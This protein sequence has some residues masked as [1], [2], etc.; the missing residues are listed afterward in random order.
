MTASSI[1]H[2]KKTENPFYGMVNTLSM[3]QNV[4]KVADNPSKSVIFSHLDQAWKECKESIDKRQLFFSIM[5]SFGDITNREHNI[6]RKKAIK[7]EQGG[8]ANRRIFL[9]CLEWMHINVPEQFYKFLPIFGEYYNL[10]AA[11]MMNIIWTDRFK[12]IVTDTFKINVNVDRL[13]T[14]IADTLKALSTTENELKLW[15]KWLWHVPSAKRKRKFIVTEKGLNSV[16]KKIN[17]NAVVGDIVTRV[18]DKLSETK[19]KDK[20]V[21]AC[22]EALSKKMGWEV[23]TFGTNKRYVGYCEFRTKYLVETE[24]VLFSTGKIKEMDKVQLLSWFETLPGGARHRVQRRIV[25]KATNGALTPKTKWVTIKGLNIGEVYVEWL[26][27]KELAQQAMRDLT[28][29]DK[30]KLVKEDPTKLKQMEKAAKVN[31]GGET[32]IDILVELFTKASRET[33]NLKAHSLIEQM[34]LLV[35]VLICADVS[36][37]TASRPITYKGVTF[38][39]QAFIRLLTTVFLLKNPNPELADMFMRFDSNA[40]VITGGQK[41]LEVVGSNRFMSGQNKDVGVLTDP[42]VDFVTNWESVSQW[43]ISRGGTNISSIAQG[44][45]KWVDEGGETWRN[46]RIE[47][48]Q[49]YP[50]FLIVSDGDI[51]NEYNAKTSVLDFQM[52]M[53]QWFGWEG[54]VVIWDVQQHF[55]PSSKFEGLTNVIHYV[56]FNPAMITQ[57]FTNLHDLDIIDVYQVLQ[58]FARTNRYQPVKELVI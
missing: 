43:I 29:E 31:T 52:K 2:S 27:S 40:E 51:N 18:A 41:G 26:K 23:K 42:K 48:I 13:T 21:Y 8:S 20:F 50:V 56:G 22:I 3:L 58:T 35:P 32:L 37:S 57:I 7:A 36:G 33:S 5:F 6:F 17:A 49:K 14:F 38:T 45:K 10:G 47:M 4:S 46:Y 54:V 24:A 28:K 16:K 12:G 1:T 9:F 30:E 53:R 25:E 11:T 19:K 15:A 44:L 39:P 34:K 55:V